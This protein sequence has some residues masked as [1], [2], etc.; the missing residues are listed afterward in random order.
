VKTITST[1]TALVGSGKPL[2]LRQ[3]TSIQIQKTVLS[4]MIS[5]VNMTKKRKSKAMVGY[6][7]LKQIDTGKIA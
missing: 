6:L 1:H 3:S 7:L 5:A 2:L 4:T